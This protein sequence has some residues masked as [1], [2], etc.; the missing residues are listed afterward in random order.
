MLINDLNRHNNAL[1]GE[2]DAAIQQVFKRGWFV[3]GPEVSAFEKEF[4]TYCGTTE[5]VTVANGTDALELALR[6]LEVKPGDEVITVANAGMYS[7]VAILATGAQ[8]VFADIEPQTLTLD[9]A[10]VRAALTPRTAAVIVTHLYGQM[11]DMPSLLAVTAAA[12]IPLIEDCAQAHGARLHNRKAGS[13]GT[14]GCFSFYPTK[15]L[16]ALGDGGAITTHDLRLAAKLRQLRQYGWEQKYFVTLGGGRNSRLDELQ[17]AILRV[18]LPHLDTWNQQRRAIAQAYAGV[19]HSGLS[20]PIGNG[21][22]YVAHLYVVRTAHRTALQRHLQASS[23]ASDIHYPLP[24][25][26]QSILAERFQRLVLPHTEAA[27]AEV[28]TLPCY[29]ELTDAEVTTIIAAL[30]AWES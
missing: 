5:C 26:H 22:D 20:L 3:L 15:N 21:E 9:P 13:W 24:D 19:H 23:I 12:G 2:F 17:A 29:P 18:K 28:L 14:L 11:A 10:T 4:A 1:K 8:P 7:T 27:T 16:G 6:V 30:E 25:Y